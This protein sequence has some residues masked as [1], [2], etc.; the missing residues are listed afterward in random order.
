MFKFVLW[1]QTTTKSRRREQKW[2][3]AGA[4][5]DSFHSVRRSQCPVKLAC[6]LGMPNLGIIIQS[7]FFRSL[8]IWSPF[9]WVIVKTNTFIYIIH[10]FICISCIH[11]YTMFLTWIV[12]L[13]GRTRL[14]R[15]WWQGRRRG[16]ASGFGAGSSGQPPTQKHASYGRS[17]PN[18]PFLRLRCW[19]CQS[20]SCAAM[21][22]MW[23]PDSGRNGLFKF[24]TPVEPLL[25][26]DMQVLMVKK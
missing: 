16:L 21:A 12:C 2:R 4:V 14:G 18:R 6:V 23:L 24:Q 3:P 8:C 20:S 22:K 11:V 9:F 5:T 26:D 13:P 10:V 19:T 15:R 17:D 7:C 25:G 1:S